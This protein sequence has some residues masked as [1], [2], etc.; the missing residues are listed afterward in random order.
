MIAYSLKV[1]VKI[2]RIKQQILHSFENLNI[3]K[4]L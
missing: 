1:Q 4:T 3:D 2:Y